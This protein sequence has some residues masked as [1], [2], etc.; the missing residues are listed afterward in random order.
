ME[1]KDLNS[2]PLEELLRSLL[3]NEIVLE[4][5]DEGKKKK[6]NKKEE[7]GVALKASTQIH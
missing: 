4:E 7:L 2:L 1:A 3:S 5:E 6:K